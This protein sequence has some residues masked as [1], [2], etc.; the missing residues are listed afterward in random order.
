ML[1]NRQLSDRRGAVDKDERCVW[2]HASTLWI[3]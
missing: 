1:R 3:G 2:R